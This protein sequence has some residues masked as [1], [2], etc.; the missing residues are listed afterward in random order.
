MAPKTANTAM[1]P[2]FNGYSVGAQKIM[3]AAER[4]IGERGVD[5]VSVR[6]IIR[7]AGQANN[8]AVYHHFGDKRGLIQAVFDTRMPP[9]DAAH[10]R[11]LD[12]AD[13]AGPIGV[14][15]LLEALWLPLADEG[16]RAF[17]RFLGQLTY[18]FPPQDHPVIHARHLAPTAAEIDTRLREHLPPMSDE[19][20]DTRMRLVTGLVLKGTAESEHFVAAN[21]S[22]KA[23]REYLSDLLRMAAAALCAPSN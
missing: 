23:L 5:A 12:A 8:S 4:L 16:Q 15:E 13:A 17:A 7:S 10:R 21:R 2:E 18:S 14:R 1:R 9:L 20:F 6:E 22:K 19:V 3:L 11:R